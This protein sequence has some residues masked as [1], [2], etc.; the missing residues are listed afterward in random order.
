MLSWP[1]SLLLVLLFGTQAL[2][3]LPPAPSAP[4]AEVFIQSP[5]DGAEVAPSFVVRFGLMGMGVAPAGIDQLHT[6]HHHLLI[7]TSEI[8]ALDMPLPA[9]D[10]IVHFG[11]GQTETTV[12]L[13]PGEH[14]L[15]LVLGDY[16]HR[17]HDPPLISKPITVTVVEPEA[18]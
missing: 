15:Q 14:T 12:T 8:P 3:Q 1:K 13:P 5:L 9:T 11:K 17:P 2:A 4:G 6:G 7:D 10:T 16:L 18:G